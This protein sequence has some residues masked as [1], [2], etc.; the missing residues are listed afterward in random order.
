MFVA[1]TVVPLLGIPLGVGITV[2]LVKWYCRKPVWEQRNTQNGG[3]LL[4]L[5]PPLQREARALKR[6]GKVLMAAGVCVFVV[7]LIGRI[8]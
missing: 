6:I 3:K 2:G 1:S 7:D 8:V 4:D 5:V